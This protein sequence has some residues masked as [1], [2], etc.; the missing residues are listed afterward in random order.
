[1]VVGCGRFDNEYTSIVSPDEV[2]TLRVSCVSFLGVPTMC[3]VINETTRTIRIENIVTEIV[4]RIVKKEV[5]T[6][7]PV[8]KIVTRV[9]TRYI[10]TRKEVDI[11]EIVEYIIARIK[12]YVESTD[13]I[14]VPIDVIVD[15]T[16]ESIINP[17]PPNKDKEETT[18]GGIRD[19]TPTPIPIPPPDE[20]K[21]G[22]ADPNSEDDEPDGGSNDDGSED[23]GTDGGSNDDGSEDDGTDGG[24][25]N[26]GPEGGTSPENLPGPDNPGGTTEGGAIE[27]LQVRIGPKKMAFPPILNQPGLSIGITCQVGGTT[28]H[29]RMYSFVVFRE[30]SRKKWWGV[31]VWCEV[32]SGLN[33]PDTTISV[34]VSDFSRWCGLTTGDISVSKFFENPDGSSHG[35]GSVAAGIELSPNPV[36]ECVIEPP[37]NRAPMFIEDSPTTRFIEENTAP[38]FA[39]GNPVSATNEDDDTLEYTL[40][41]TDGASFSIDSA[42]GQLKTSDP[43]NYEVKDSYSVLVTASD[44]EGDTAEITVTISVTNGNDAPMFT[45]AS[46]ADR[47]VEENTVSGEFFGT[48]VSATDEDDDTLTYTI[49]LLVPGAFGIEST[50]GQLKTSAALDYETKGLYWATVYV[51]DNRGGTAS[52]TVRIGVTDANDAPMFTEEDPATRV[53]IESAASGTNIGHAVSATDEDDDMLEYSLSGTDAGS[54][55]IN[56]STGRLSTNTQ[57]DYD[58]QSSYSVTVSVFDNK[59][60]TDEITVT[61]EVLEFYIPQEEFF[62][63]YYAI[64]LAYGSLEV[65]CY[66]IRGYGYDNGTPIYVDNYYKFEGG[67]SYQTSTGWESTANEVAIA[68]DLEDWRDDFLEDDGYVHG[69]TKVSVHDRTAGAARKMIYQTICN[70]AKNRGT[71]ESSSAEGISYPGIANNTSDDI[72]DQA[73]IFSYLEDDDCDPDN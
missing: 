29:P 59:G 36:P 67:S 58:T 21:D 39:I 64:Y 18:L 68:E 20:D 35:G 41:G 16:T 17:P 61:I 28:I 65:Q 13:L 8:E 37:G 4:N 66:T 15:E 14:D 22:T 73:T 53:I 2:S 60:G 1:M 51:S 46:P 23:D 57:L 55:S 10:V 63:V 70:V 50:T 62:E 6:E 32:P 12:E 38:G 7:V 31:S 30:D 5:V 42:T 24:S 3:A 47:S 56:S 27:K 48:P 43:L 71:W 54:F 40:G 49:A 34:N 52:I 9:E 19:E 25:N 72:L 33:D 11:E 45:D 44:N 26:G 69:S